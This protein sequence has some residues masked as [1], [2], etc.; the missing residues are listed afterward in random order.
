MVSYLCG[1][2]IYNG[3]QMLPLGC[4]QVLLLLEPPLELV[5]LGLGE[6]YASLSPLRKRKLHRADGHADP[7]TYTHA[8][9][10][11]HVAHGL[12]HRAA[13]HVRACARGCSHQTRYWKQ[14]VMFN[15]TI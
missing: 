14:S 8:R 3:G 1:S 4:A 5:N 6:Q 10:L 15:L 9:G 11:G 7:D 2:E 13:G 12:A